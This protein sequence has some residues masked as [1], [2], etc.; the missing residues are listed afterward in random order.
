MY[1][2]APTIT[3]IGN[4]EGMPCRIDGSE[5]SAQ[6][7]AAFDVALRDLRPR[8][9]GMPLGKLLGA[10]RDSAPWY[11]TS[12]GYL[13]AS[14]SEALGSVETSLRRGQGGIKLEV[15]Q[16]ELAKHIERVAA[17]AHGSASGTD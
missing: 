9:A 5:M 2:P 6:A 12:G 16:P 17:V 4:S 8:V 14:T 1:Q 15:G 11:N 3:P 13:S 10:Y 7:I